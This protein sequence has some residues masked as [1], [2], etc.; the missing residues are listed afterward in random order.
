MTSP[1]YENARFS[2]KKRLV[3]EN[4]DVSNAQIKSFCEEGGYNEKDVRVKIKM[5]E[6]FRW[7]FVKDPIKQNIY[8]ELFLEYIEQFDGISNA[9]KP[10]PAI[11][12]YNGRILTTQKIK[13]ENIKPPCKTIDFSFNFKNK[14]IFIY[15]KYAKDSGGH[16]NNQYKDL[17][18][19]INEANKVK[20]SDAFFIVVVDGKFWKTKN[21]NAKKQKIDN[22]K[23]V[24][25]KKNTFATYSG[26]LFD[27]LSILK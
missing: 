26:G 4:K 14:D 1:D 27:V 23:D 24:A 18:C 16:Q 11:Q 12:L 3:K 10:S 25:N 2:K 7:H 17:L 19:F 6:M 20:I 22:L 5:D 21:G 9:K 8:E 13:N 15:H